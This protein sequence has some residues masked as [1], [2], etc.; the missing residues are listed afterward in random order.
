MNNV[1]SVCE[2]CSGSYNTNSIVATLGKRQ[3]RDKKHLHGREPRSVLLPSSISPRYNFTSPE[4]DC[5]IF[6]RLPLPREALS[7]VHQPFSTKPIAC[8]TSPL[9][10]FRAATGS[11]KS[12]FSLSMAVPCSLVGFK[13]ANF[14]CMS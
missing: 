14:A 11:C 8:N 2:Y 10:R 9:H 1:S 7:P 6:S 12:S 5:L 3:P 4:I 13:R